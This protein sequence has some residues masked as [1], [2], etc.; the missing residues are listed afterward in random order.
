MQKTPVEIKAQSAPVD[1]LIL[2][3]VIT[4]VYG[5]VLFANQMQGTFTP[6][7]EISLQPSKLPLYTFFS[8]LRGL[9]AYMISL[10]FTLIVGYWAAKSRAA[11]RIILPFLDIMQSIPV[12]GF[13]PG[14]V[15]GL[16]AIFPHTNMGLELAAIFMIFTG[17][18]WNMTFSFY[19]SLRSIPK[20]LQEAATILSL[21]P[22][23]KFFRLEL[24]YSAVNLTWNSI[25]SMAGGWFFLSIC[26]A[27]TLGSTSYRLP[28]LGAYMSVAI[29]QGNT[30]AIISGI[31]S[32]MALILIIDILIWRPVLAWVHRFRL[33]DL[34]GSEPEPPIVELL[35]KDSLL[36]RYALSLR[37]RR[38]RFASQRVR[39]IQ[40]FER[41]TAFYRRFFV[42]RKFSWRPILWVLGSATFIVLGFALWRMIDILGS[43]TWI[44][45]SEI[46]LSVFATA[47]R[48]FG[49]LVLA[50]LWTVPFGIWLGQSPQ[51]LRWAQPFVQIAASFPA[52]M[53]YPLVL[54]ALLI[55][56]VPFSIG[57]MFLM[58]LGVQ[59]Y[60]LFNVLAGA[61]RISIELQQVSELMS[62]SQ[63][64]KWRYLYLP[65]VLPS[66]VTGWVTAAGGAWNASIVAEY[67]NY[68][69]QTLMT[70]GLGAQI[71]RAALEADFPRLAASLVVMV[72]T[73]V[74]INRL[75]W[76]RVYRITSERYKLEQ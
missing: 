12:L 70:T 27:F 2:M 22:V 30:K 76:S 18:V 28:G 50:S 10:I 16:I 31:M 43:V 52:P 45:W 6:Q 64:N 25:M 67:A 68:Q 56:K 65:S 8:A 5:V 44:E 51:R 1:L 24:P 66:L 13:L 63:L 17:Q 36:L 40:V 3:F 4:F 62:V 47:L 39:W 37:T 7:T 74:L 23:M 58:L 20:D 53:L 60:V 49:C 14:L 11:E 21:S 38:P 55:F 42:L 19:A 29:E 46:I 41:A 75:L 26:E 71:S 73:V 72:V 48:V 9:T 35:I 59:W 54:G 57:S 69:G 15:L 34:P 33:E 32:M 61:L